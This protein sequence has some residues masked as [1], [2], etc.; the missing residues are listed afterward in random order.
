[1][2][3]LSSL[4]PLIVAW[5][6]TNRH[7]L[8]SNESNIGIVPNL[9]CQQALTSY[10]IVLATAPCLRSF[11]SSFHTGGIREVVELESR[12]DRKIGRIDV[13][14]RITDAIRSTQT[15]FNSFTKRSEQR[16]E[17]AFRP[18]LENSYWTRVWRADI[19]PEEERHSDL[20]TIMVVRSYEV[21]YLD[22][23]TPSQARKLLATL[24]PP[25]SSSGSDT[26]DLD[27]LTSAV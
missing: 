12:K 23:V 1:M 26:K 7:F 2:L 11:V 10:A 3:T 16:N 25:P 15:A 18:D 14:A 6:R 27:F 24:P 21:E 5:F 17:L 8:S 19:I 4:L 20:E 13:V 9:I 22:Q